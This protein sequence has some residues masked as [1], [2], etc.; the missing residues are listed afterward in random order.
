MHL[1]LVWKMEAAVPRSAVM[2]GIL[3]L[4]LEDLAPLKKFALWI[5]LIAEPFAEI[6]DPNRRILQNA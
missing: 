4:P 5:V 6:V 1:H 2:I 3:C